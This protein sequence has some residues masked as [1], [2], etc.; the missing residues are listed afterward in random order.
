M[1]P[2][3][4]NE[5][6]TLSKIVSENLK[7]YILDYQ[8][9][10]GQ[11]LP[12][13]RDLVKMLNVSRT[14][15]REALRILESTGIITIRHGEGAYVQDDSN[16]SSLFEHMIFMWKLG[17]KTRGDLLELRH[18]F[19]LTAI[20]Q[21]VQRASDEDLEAL[22]QLA[23]R[24]QAFTDTKSIQDADIE[25]HRGLLKATNNKLFVQMTDL[26]IE[27]FANVPH[28]HMDAI[29]RDKSVSDHLRIVEALRERDAAKGKQL[30][31][32]HLN[33]SKKYMQ[34]VNESL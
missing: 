9:V 27:Y 22:E 20:E 21:A 18:I 8:L 28:D 12:S 33:Y 11:K 19:E 1:K 16:L 23:L 2:I 25:F 4:K 30:L 3:Q 15:L 24:M 6:L 7:E 5:R 26:I 29:E 34:S 17:N 13:E 14:V 31:T 10:P 32:S